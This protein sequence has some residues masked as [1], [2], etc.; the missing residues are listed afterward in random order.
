MVLTVLEG[1]VA[2]DRAAD[3]ENAFR[4]GQGKTPPESFA[5][6][7]GSLPA[8]GGGDQIPPNSVL[9]FEMEAMSVF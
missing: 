4:A 9:V 1:S 6:R 5:T 7:V 3:L 8:S 2:P